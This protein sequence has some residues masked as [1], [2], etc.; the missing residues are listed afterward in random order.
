MEEAAARFR[1]LKV[2]C[3]AMSLNRNQYGS[4]CLEDCRGCK[5]NHLIAEQAE[6]AVAASVL[7][8]RRGRS[9]TTQKQ[10]TSK[11]HKYDRG[12][13]NLALKP[14]LKHRNQEKGD[15]SLRKTYL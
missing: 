8:G 13:G 6:V 15:Y 9:M 5:E 4:N 7:E 10:E 11:A 3:A 14:K 1:N 2:E 12:I